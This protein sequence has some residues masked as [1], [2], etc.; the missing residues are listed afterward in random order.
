MA[1]PAKQQFEKF[2]A[3]VTKRLHEPNKIN[4]ALGQVE[5][6]TGVD[7]FFVVISAF[8]LVIFLYVI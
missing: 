6:K 2:R 8:L 5:S 4:D 1:A 7:R 3:D